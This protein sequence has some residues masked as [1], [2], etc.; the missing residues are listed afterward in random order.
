MSTL[1]VMEEKLEILLK[2]AMAN[3]QEDGF[4]VLI[5]FRNS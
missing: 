4:L 3:L 5:T 1:S 2:K